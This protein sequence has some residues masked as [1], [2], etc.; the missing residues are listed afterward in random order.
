LCQKSRTKKLARAACEQP[1]HSQRARP[2]TTAAQLPKLRRQS[3]QQTGNTPAV[4]TLTRVVPK[5]ATTDRD[6]STAEL[7]MWVAD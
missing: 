2:R 4:A 5:A 1:R 6:T 3:A 7:T